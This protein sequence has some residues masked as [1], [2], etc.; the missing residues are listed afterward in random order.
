VAEAKTKPTDASVEKHIAAI[1]NEER[2][3]DARRLVTLLRRVTGEAPKMWGP[4]IVGFGSYHY[5]YDSGREG[6]SALAGFAVRK[7][8]LTVYIVAGFEG[9]EAL[10]E[11]LGKHRTAKVCLYMKR[12][13]DVD[14]EV[15]ER[16]VTD[17]V[18]EMKRRYPSAR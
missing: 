18:A 12:L 15:L 11:K 1:A 10:L 3:A 14:V 13:A 2:R 17:S 7:S 5:K 6:D 4:S 16:L 9:R 8:D